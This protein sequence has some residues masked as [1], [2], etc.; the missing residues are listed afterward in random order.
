MLSVILITHSFNKYL[1]LLCMYRLYSR[2]YGG[3]MNYRLMLC[4]LSF[5][6]SLNGLE[7]NAHDNQFHFLGLTFVRCPLSITCLYS[8][9]WQKNRDYKSILSAE[10]NNLKECSC[11]VFIG[12]VTKAK[13]S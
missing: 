13:V 9:S 10:E 5:V 6:V 1:L 11:K 8:E 12:C 7:Y 3:Y 4:E 2:C